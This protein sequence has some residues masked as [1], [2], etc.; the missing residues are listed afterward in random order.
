MT[1]TAEMKTLMTSFQQMP[2]TADAHSHKPHL[3]LQAQNMLTNISCKYSLRNPRPYEAF[4][5]VAHEIQEETKQLQCFTDPVDYASGKP[6][7]PGSRAP[8]NEVEEYDM[9]VTQNK[10][11]LFG[12]PHNKD[13]S[14]LGSI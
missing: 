13:Y 9:G 7:L 14:I 2:Q 8:A 5:Q 1:G 3:K 4:P 12:G 10:G 11:F 6:P